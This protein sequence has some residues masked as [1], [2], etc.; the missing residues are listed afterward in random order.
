M[1]PYTFYKVVHLI[2]IALVVSALG[3]TAV[4]AMSGGTKQTNGARGLQAA[5]HG[6][7]ALLILVGGFGMLAR[8]GFSHGAMFPGWLI[9]KLLVWVTAAALLF[10]PYRK[11][12]LAR[13]I[14]L[15]VPV[16]VG[17]ATYMA[18]YKPI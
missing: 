2:G 12:S 16:L 5:L 13:P 11:P 14:Y 4:H 1:L 15:A 17:L 8:L 6:V 10:V 9:V 18:V 7:G 3:G